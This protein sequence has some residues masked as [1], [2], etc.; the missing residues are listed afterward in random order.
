MH[1]YR[2]PSGSYYQV[3]EPGLL[4]VASQCG[5]QKRHRI[6]VGTGIDGVLTSSTARLR[7]FS[8]SRS[9]GRRRGTTAHT[10]RREGN[11]QSHL[12]DSRRTHQPIPL[13]IATTAGPK[14]Q[15]AP[16]EG[17]S[18]SGRVRPAVISPARSSGTSHA[19]S[20]LDRNSPLTPSPMS[21]EC[22][23]LNDHRTQRTQFIHNDTARQGRKASSM[24]SPA[25][26]SPTTTASSSAMQVTMCSSAATNDNAC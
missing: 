7:F 2:V 12:K 23:R 8:A 25:R 9:H 20:E 14:P 17:H 15:S 26:I 21:T 11:P 10:N 3:V 13:T 16:K 6:L 18:V 5:P 1:T 24:P 22:R 4:W 19:F